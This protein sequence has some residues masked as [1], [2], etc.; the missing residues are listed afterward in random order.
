MF[1]RRFTP[2]C[3]QFFRRYQKQER[4]VK[5]QVKVIFLYLIYPEIFENESNMDCS[6]NRHCNR[7]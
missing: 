2:Q 4:T 1:S 7:H 3:M 5:H 6:G